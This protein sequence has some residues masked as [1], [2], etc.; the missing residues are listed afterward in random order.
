[1]NTNT[2]LA[3][4]PGRN[5]MGYAVF[6]ENKLFYYGGTLLS[7]Y[8]TKESVLIAVEKFLK[9]IFTK[10]RISHLAIQKLIKQQELSTL[11]VLITAQI[12]TIANK[13]NVSVHE[14][15]PMYIRQQFCRDEK[16][17][18][19]NTTKTLTARYAELNRYYNR[20]S[21]WERKY[22]DY[23]F[24]AIATGIICAE[25]LKKSKNSRNV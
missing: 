3:I 18:K 9:R 14:Y 6:S 16:S 23:V 4:S 11:L 19:A 22:Y 25:E 8:K 12:K 10:Y 17:T 20:T 7:R 1:M 15:S 13:Q 24:T 21:E 2:I 5:R